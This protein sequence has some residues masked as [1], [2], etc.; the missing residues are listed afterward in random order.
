MSDKEQKPTPP[1]IPL[2]EVVIP[3]PGREISEK[4]SLPTFY[5]PPPPPPP[6]SPSQ[7]NDSA[8]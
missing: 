3:Q 4:N 1:R 7:A 8:E 5:N 6:P 2:R